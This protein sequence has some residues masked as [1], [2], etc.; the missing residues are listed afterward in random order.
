MKEIIKKTE[1]VVWDFDGTLVATPL[2]ES[3]KLVYE[4][5]TG[6]KWPHVGWWGKADSLDT[7]V[8]EM[9]TIPMTIDFYNQ[10][11]EKEDALK[12]MMTGR[13]IKLESH[14]MKILKEKG[15]SFDE[16]H[17]NRGGSTDVAKIKTMES[18]MAKIDTIET[19]T[20]FEDRLEHVEIFQKWG[21]EMVTKG[22]L[23]SFSITLI[24]SDNHK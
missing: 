6:K 4:E 22:F 9:E 16:Y 14:V 21:D 1:L 19:V 5:K 13:M 17:F 2:P 7:D 10:Y 24:P 11:L 23:K 18:I 20:M 12:I 3:G 8:F 15:L